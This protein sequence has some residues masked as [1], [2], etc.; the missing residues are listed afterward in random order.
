M[1]NSQI[2]ARKKELIDR[3][4]N[5]IKSTQEYLANIGFKDL[6][7]SLQTKVDQL[8][9]NHRRRS[10]LIGN[11]GEKVYVDALVNVITYLDLLRTSIQKAP[12]STVTM[13]VEGKPKEFTLDDMSKK[14]ELTVKDLISTKQKIED[15]RK[16]DTTHMAA[17]GSIKLND[18]DMGSSAEGPERRAPNLLRGIS[19]EST[20]STES[21]TPAKGA[22]A[23]DKGTERDVWDTNPQEEYSAELV[24]SE[25][26]EQAESDDQAKPD[27]QAEI[28]AQAANKEKAAK[29]EKV[30]AGTKKEEVNLTGWDTSGN[31]ED[32]P[33]SLSNLGSDEGPSDQVEG[34]TIHGLSRPPPLKMYE[35]HL[36]KDDDKEHTQDEE[37][38]PD[39]DSGVDHY[40]TPKSTRSPK[41]PKT[42][43]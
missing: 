15:A 11:V 40:K 17:R 33:D 9:K 24:F 16:Q 19:T 5:E 21:A 29:A 28:G 22:K 6:A 14:L 12:S 18:S 10:Q 34:S 8:F 37:S 41:T 7:E 38:A 23:K 31:A 4:N 42:P 25:P 43:K 1:E 30:D 39:A 2:L 13:D 20:S 35:A 27:K 32:F 26:G 36:A 3:I